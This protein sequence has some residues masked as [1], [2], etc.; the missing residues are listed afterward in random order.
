M[1]PTSA[2]L[3]KSKNLYE[4][5]FLKIPNCPKNCKKDLYCVYQGMTILF[6]YLLYVLITV[7]MYTNKVF[8]LTYLGHWSISINYD[9]I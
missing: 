9:Y 4:V 1:I 8:I 7:P 3:I 5:N 2:E 6:Y